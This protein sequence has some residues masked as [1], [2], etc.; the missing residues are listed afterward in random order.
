MISTGF[1][2]FG[3]K[4]TSFVFPNNRVSHLDLLEK[5]GYASYRDEGGLLK[6]GMFVLRKGQ[7]YDI[8]PG[9]HLGFTYNPI[10]LNKIIDIAVTRF[11]P[12]HIWFHPRDIFET[13]GSMQK[14]IEGV[15]YPL[16]NY[17]KKKEKEGTLKFETMHSIVNKIQTRA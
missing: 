14:N 6:D 12:F 4:P 17:A 1:Q 10:F 5:F 13:R 9:F 7:L 11:L 16:Y 2:K 8:H 15:L 3:V